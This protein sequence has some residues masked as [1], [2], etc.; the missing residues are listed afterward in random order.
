MRRQPAYIRFRA[1]TPG[2]FGGGSSVLV[3]TTAGGVRRAPAVCVPA[4]A[5]QAEHPAPRHV[6]SR[7]NR[8]IPLRVP[9]ARQHSNSNRDA[10]PRAPSVLPDPRDDATTQLGSAH[11]SKSY[12]RNARKMDCA[13]RAARRDAILWMKRYQQE[14]AP[15]F[16]WVKHPWTACECF[17]A[18]RSKPRV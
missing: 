3:V 17:C 2:Q 9:V 15:L 6:P 16:I 13:N 14:I 18:L 1:V 10:D 11:D 7:K 4:L 8:P 12:A 5:Q